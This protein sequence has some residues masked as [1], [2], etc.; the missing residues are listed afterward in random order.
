MAQPRRPQQRLPPLPRPPS[1]PAIN[2]APLRSRQSVELD[3]RQSRAG[4]QWP[5]FE[6]WDKF[7]SSF[8]WLQGEHLTTIGPTGSGKTVLNRELLKRR[9][10]VIVLGFKNRD[11]ELYGPFQAMGYELERSFDPVPTADTN[12]KLVLFVPRTEKHGAE[13]RAVKGRRFR[14]VLNDV[15]DV[16]DWTVYVDDLQYASDQL[17]L[18]PELEEI[19]MLGR[20]EGVTLVGSSQEPV[21][22]PPM[23]YNAAVHL[24]LFAN[25]DDYRAERMGKLAGI[26]RQ[27]VRE[28]VLALPDHE[29]LYL[30]RKTGQM[31]RSMVLLRR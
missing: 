24:F 21:D 25:R 28:V 15:Y 26:N 12:E 9:D 17:R 20:S 11:A 8:R 4:D 29:F 13:G 2:L 10:Y 18:A 30:N 31:V 27:L 23:A 1:F 3:G 6:R 22:I 16:G 14:Q 19:W 7:M 5:P